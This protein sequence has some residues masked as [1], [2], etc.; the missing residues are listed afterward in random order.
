MRLYFDDLLQTVEL[1]RKGHAPDQQRGSH[2]RQTH[3][4]LLGLSLYL[5]GQL[6][7]GCQYEGHRTRCTLGFLLKET[8]RTK[9]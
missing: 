1:W 3:H 7:G 4:H 6:P 8:N 9:E 5:N 2:V